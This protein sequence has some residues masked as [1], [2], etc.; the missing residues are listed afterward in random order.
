LIDV[1][2]GLS[3]TLKTFSLLK[4]TAGS[5][6]ATRSFNGAGEVVWLATFTDRTEAIMVTKVP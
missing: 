4:A 1:G 6:G 3:K 5:T 2:G